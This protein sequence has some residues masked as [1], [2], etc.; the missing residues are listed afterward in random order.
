MS[1]IRELVGVEP[2]INPEFR[3]GSSMDC[4]REIY[5]RGLKSVCGIHQETAQEVDI[6]TA[7]KSLDISREIDLFISLGYPRQRPP[8][9]PYKDG[10]Q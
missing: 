4:H 2:M 3:P 10:R 9:V 6:A 5:A 1:R 7:R 8:R